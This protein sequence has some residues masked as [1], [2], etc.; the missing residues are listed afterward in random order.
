M[1]SFFSQVNV[2]RVLFAGLVL[3]LFAGFLGGCSVEPEDDT[4]YEGTL[5]G[6]VGKWVADYGDFFVITGSGS[7]GTIKY[8]WDSS[9]STPGSEGN[10]EFVSNYD[11]SSGVIIVKYTRGA[12]DPGKPF[13]AFYYLNL[14]GTTVSIN[15]AYDVSNWENDVKTATREQ[16]I[17]K[18]T[19]GSMGNWID[20]SYAVPYTKQN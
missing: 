11:S 8:Y 1:F 19:K 5:D 9:S 18:F 10:I 20:P 17:E 14:T 15:E 16:A 2:K 6:L 3:V 7:S 13:G 12:T 4:N